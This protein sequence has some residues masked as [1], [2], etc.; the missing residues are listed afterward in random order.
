MTELEYDSYLKKNIAH[1]AARRKGGSKS[2]RCPLSTDYM[3]RKQW[4]ERCGEVVSYQI[5][6]P[7]VWAE[8][9]K[10]PSDLKEEYMNNLIRK[11]SANARNMAD[12]FGVS[13]A[14]VFRVVKKENLNVEF[15]K[16]RHPVG[17]KQE[18]F[19]K[20]LSGDDEIANSDGEM[21]DV[22]CTADNES[23]QKLEFDK[24]D[25][26]AQDSTE[27]MQLSSF[28]MNFSGLV[29]VDMIANSLRYIL[30]TEKT[31]DIQITCTIK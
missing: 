19:Q 16:G 15:L 26:P 11:Y 29:N 18:Q 6:R 31:A 23:E 22:E 1:S 7:M 17:N 3:S 14:T 28:S 12:M 8:F 9:N 13:V 4:E 5:G 27:K 30:G 21:P 20:F 10:L 2:K 25:K 24:K